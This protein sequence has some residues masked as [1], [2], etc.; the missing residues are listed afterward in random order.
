MMNLNRGTC[1]Q[2]RPAWD[3]TMEIVA[4]LERADARSQPSGRQPSHPRGRSP[5]ASGMALAAAKRLETI[6]PARDIPSMPSHIH[7]ARLQLPPTP[8][9]TAK[10]DKDY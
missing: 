3:K 2:G 7:A 10:V 9:I 5:A 4:V 6:A 1:D 8:T